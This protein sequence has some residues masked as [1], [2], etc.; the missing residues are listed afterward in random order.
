MGVQAITQKLQ[1]CIDDESTTQ[2]QLALLFG[3]RG[4]Q[5]WKITSRRENLKL[6]LIRHSWFAQIN[7]S[8]RN[9]TKAIGF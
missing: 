5:A 7:W 9:A 8:F 2:Y 6:I 3:W 4:A 1:V